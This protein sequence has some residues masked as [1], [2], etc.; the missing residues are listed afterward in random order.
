MGKL[1]FSVRSAI[2][3][4]AMAGF[5][6]PFG[7]ASE[8]EMA[9][10]LMGL[11][12]D[13]VVTVAETNDF[14]QSLMNKKS[15]Q[16]N[17][18]PL[19]DGTLKD[20]LSP[21]EAAV[22]FRFFQTQLPGIKFEAGT[23]EAALNWAAVIDLTPALRGQVQA[24]R[25]FSGTTVPQ[26]VRDL[27]AKARLA[28]AV[29]YDPDFDDLSPYGGSIRKTTGNMAWDYTEVTPSKLLALK[30]DTTTPSSWFGGWEQVSDAKHAIHVPGFGAGASTTMS[31]HHPW[32]LREEDEFLRGPQGQI[33]ANNCGILI[34]GTLQCLPYT[35]V[36]P[37]FDFLMTDNHVSRGLPM[38]FHGHIDIKDG[39]VIHVEMSGKLCKAA[40]DGDFVFLDP[41]T[42]LK[43]WGFEMAPDM[44]IEF[45]NLEKGIPVRDEVSG[46]L[47]KKKL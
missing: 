29:A 40:A 7:W 14:F 16:P 37:G 46:T 23:R 32:D 15:H 2:F 35:R 12:S 45:S 36:T 4:F 20:R 42:F 9:D 25:A 17:A 11:S 6:G 33:W 38:L 13:G 22:L 44:D 41:V 18:Y 31:Y 47:R 5:L 34:D 26:A 3:T 1:W 21:K 27:I 43:A 39:V 8:S 10:A 30:A 19:I 24:G 28:G